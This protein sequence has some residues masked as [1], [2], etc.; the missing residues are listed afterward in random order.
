MEKGA[1]LSAYLSG[2]V[3]SLFG[4]VTLQ[5]FAVWVGIVATVATFAVNW[6]YKAK[7]ARRVERGLR[8]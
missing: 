7:E 5:D 6:Y 4:V 2:V 8:L 1:S 3:T